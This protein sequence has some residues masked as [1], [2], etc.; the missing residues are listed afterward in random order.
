MGFSHRI[1]F[2]CACFR[3]RNYASHYSVRNL[4]DHVGGVCEESNLIEL[5]AVLEVYLKDFKLK[6]DDSS[7]IEWI[8]EY[9]MLLELLEDSI[10]KLMGVKGK[11]QVF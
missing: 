9:Y 2:S 8:G 4:L 6:K 11:L 5:V 7:K 10:N 3:C 1:N